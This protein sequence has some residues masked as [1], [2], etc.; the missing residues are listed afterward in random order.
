MKILVIAPHPD[1]EVLGCGGTIKNHVN[2]GDQ[3][4][5][6][7]VTKAYTPDWSEDFITSRA[8]EIK[9][10]NEIL[11]ITKTFFLDFP[12]A[13]LDTVPHKDVNHAID[14]VIKEVSPEVVYVPYE[15]DL[16]KDHQIVFHSSL[17]A[18][19]PAHTVSVKKILSYE[20]LSETDWASSSAVF[21]PNIYEDILSTIE[22]KI[23]AMEAYQSEVRP[24][25]H[26]RSLE[27]LKVLAQKRGVEVNLEFAEA[28]K[29]IREIK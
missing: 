6:C 3:V 16:H 4:Y 9:K 28:F 7:I 22:D 8:K 2:K 1:D 10:S 14:K 26:S 12:A 11:G 25:P 23:K 19:R 5:L 15:G 29:L 20:V 21:A 27:M 17:V 13:K 18:T 24:Y